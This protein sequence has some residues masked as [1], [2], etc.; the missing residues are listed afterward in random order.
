MFL[1]LA[2]A[3]ALSPEITSLPTPPISH[4]GIAVPAVAMAQDRDGIAIAWTSQGNDGFYSIDVARIDRHGYVAG[5][6]REMPR[7]SV[8]SGA[9]APSIAALPSGHGFTIA[10][11]EN[12]NA[13]YCQV[14]AQLEPLSPSRVFTTQKTIAPVIVRS[15]KETWLTTGGVT[16]R[17]AGDGTVA[18]RYDSGF[19][20]SDVDASGDLLRIVASHRITTVDDSQCGCTRVGAGPFRGLCP[21]PIYQYS[22]GL[23]FVSLFSFAQST[24]FPFDSQLQPAVLDTGSETLIAWF[25]GPENQGGDVVLTRDNLDHPPQSLGTFAPDLGPTRPDIASDGDHTVIVWRKATSDTT[26]DVVAAIVD[27]AGN[28][29]QL[30]IAASADD[31]RDPSVMSIERGVFLIAYEKVSTSERRIAGRFLTFPR[32]R[33]A[34]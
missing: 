30:T 15:G 12:P 7:A 26:H 27:A 20:A 28:V 11:L 1:A 29:T 14:D 9:A 16:G 23:D 22:Y 19:P 3:I 10:W 5:A 31:E 21:C 4:L 13:V 6:I 25:R 34:S 24:A 33:H 17:L 32:K 2:L 18:A 8:T